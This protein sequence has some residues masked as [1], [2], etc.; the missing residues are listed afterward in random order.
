MSSAGS[1]ASGRRE[2]ETLKAS[3]QVT[4]S[5][6]QQEG[7]VRTLFDGKIDIIADVH[8]EIEAVRKLMERLGYSS[9]GAHA[10]GRRMVF[11]GDL[12]DRGPDSLAV[13]DLV[14]ALIGSGRAQ[15]VLGN[16]DLN[17]ILNHKKEDNGWF[18]SERLVHRRRIVSFFRTL[19]LALERPGLRIVHACWKPEMVD[20]A[21]TA[22]GTVELYERYLDLIEADIK[23]RKNL[24]QV[25]RRLQLQNRNPVKI[26]TSGPEERSGKRILAGGEWRREK[27]VRWWKNYDEPEVCVFGHYA[28]LPTRPNG[29][30]RAI[31]ID[32]GAGR[33][34]E[35]RLNRGTAG[36]FRYKL[37]ALRFPE[38]RLVFDDTGEVKMPLSWSGDAGTA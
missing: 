30:G 28:T 33:R 14:S 27:R 37:A 34:A 6:G 24:D 18:F 31:C 21:R 10:A 11:L 4:R 38:M 26:L 29:A 15:C 1:S 17:I 22:E 3:H 32:F 5:P 13:I 7:L 16:H 8:G 23:N 35:E 12:T 9:D 36:P 20:V 19:P 2:T 25:G